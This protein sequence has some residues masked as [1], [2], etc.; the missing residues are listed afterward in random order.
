M[1]RQPYQV[2]YLILEP[3][4][5]SEAV[6]RELASR[7]TREPW[8]GSIAAAENDAAIKVH[9]LTFQPEIPIA[10]GRAAGKLAEVTIVPRG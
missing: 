9:V 3:D 10:I 2:E 4:R 1:M 8:S 7:L 6:R 5:S